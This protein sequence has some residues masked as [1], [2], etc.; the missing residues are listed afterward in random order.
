MTVK[1]KRLKC[2]PLGLR[3]VP[4]SSHSSL[5]LG[6]AGA[7]DSVLTAEAKKYIYIQ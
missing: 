2:S 3:F 1:A 7:T 5:G 4:T 6:I